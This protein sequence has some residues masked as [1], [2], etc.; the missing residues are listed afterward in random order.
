MVEFRQAACLG[1]QPL[2]LAA[3]A[4]KTRGIM[5]GVT[6]V[7][8]NLRW[9]YD[10]CASRVRRKQSARAPLPRTKRCHGQTSAWRTAIDAV[11]LM[12]RMQTTALEPHATSLNTG[13]L[14]DWRR[15]AFLP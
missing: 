5:L 12:H 13:L 14:P 8:C 1:H 7:E 9:R 4:G 3:D 15:L 11:H 6:V 10:V 2:M